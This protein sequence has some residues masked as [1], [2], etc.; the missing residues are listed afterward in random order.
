MKKVKYDFVVHRAKAAD[1][2]NFE[3]IIE[4]PLGN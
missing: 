2:P 3:A 1:R 4:N